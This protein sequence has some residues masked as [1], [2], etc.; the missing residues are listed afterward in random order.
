[1]TFLKFII[2]T[3][4]GIL[5]F[6]GHS[7]TATA[8]VNCNDVKNYIEQTSIE[9]A[10]YLIDSVEDTPQLCSYYV[11]QAF[12]DKGKN[13]EA[14]LHIKKI[15]SLNFRREDFY[16]DAL[17]LKLLLLEGELEDNE[18]SD[19]L[20]EFLN[21]GRMD[22]YN[23]LTEEKQKRFKTQYQQLCQ[24][25]FGKHTQLKI[26][27]PYLAT[28]PEKKEADT[29]LR[30]IADISDKDKKPLNQKNSEAILDAFTGL[31]TTCAAPKVDN[32]PIL[33]KHTNLVSYFELVKIVKDETKVSLKDLQERRDKGKKALAILEKYQYQTNSV[34]TLISQI[35]QKIKVTTLKGLLKH[36]RL[37]TSL[38]KVN[39][40]LTSLSKYWN[41]ETITSQLS[42]TEQKFLNILRLYDE[43]LA[44]EH[45][46]CNTLSN[47]ETGPGIQKSMVA[48]A[49]EKI[50][51]IVTQV[52]ELIQNKNNFTLKAAAKEAL[53]IQNENS[54]VIQ[55][56]S[57]EKQ[58]AIQ[59]KIQIFQDIAKAYDSADRNWIEI[60]QLSK[61]IGIIKNFDELELAKVCADK[62][63]S[64]N[65]K[66]KYLDMVAEDNEDAIKICH[67]TLSSVKC[68]DPN[69]DAK[70]IKM[71]VKF[72]MADTLMPLRL[73]SSD[74]NKFNKAIEQVNKHLTLLLSEQVDTP[75]I[76]LP[77]EILMKKLIGIGKN[78]CRATNSL[79][80]QIEDVKNFF[81][82]L[83]ILRS[84]K[85]APNQN[86]SDIDKLLATYQGVEKLITVD[87]K[88]KETL[89]EA[90][91][92]SN[93]S[94][95][96]IDEQNPT[97]NNGDSS[98]VAKAVGSTSNEI[99]QTE[100]IQAVPKNNDDKVQ[101][102]GSFGSDFN[103]QKSF[104][105]GILSDNNRLS[106]HH[107]QFT[108]VKE[109]RDI[110]GNIQYFYPYFGAGMDVWIGKKNHSDY[111][112]KKIITLA[113]AVETLRE[114]ID[115][116]NALQQANF[117]AFIGV[118]N[119]MMSDED[120]REHDNR[121]QRGVKS[122][123]TQLDKAYF[124]SS[125][126]Q[127]LWYLERQYYEKSYG[128]I[129]QVYWKYK[130][131]DEMNQFS[132]LLMK[133]ISDLG[134]LNQINPQKNCGKY[135]YDY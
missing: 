76:P 124:A 80:K 24:N 79:E 131:T 125:F 117:Q 20:N 84:A 58:N 101:K 89:V 59:S 115:N 6:F 23:K 104:F 39:T 61:S 56:L 120:I 50:N 15:T 126:F 69:L 65:T 64:I 51:N 102:S 93:S 8:A 48:F 123:V 87:A 34:K 29:I 52:N 25:P 121:I 114:G 19:A 16:L 22:L 11:A 57:R 14:R 10:I 133:A 113:K 103:W 73:V 129:C 63:N 38:S 70:L 47:K 5:F 21:V 81:I 85:K 46:S 53:R 32:H 4:I 119:D 43:C 42:S 2:A 26:D 132:R 7:D 67:T 41:N 86:R 77:V 95:A 33:V 3:I 35:E 99:K 17:Y 62:Q 54:Q 12:V 60:I 108:K 44:G 134:H 130:F 91:S 96:K 100:E 98:P 83:K 28:M 105:R 135:D 110:D 92:I 106:N 112:D 55:V 90:V 1:M 66:V 49:I 74:D 13:K 18:I 122:R 128:V 40:H 36:I 111:L 37:Q 109:R 116:P 88:L 72:I 107:R 78:H 30:L 127:G 118:I 45:L 94:V 27:S 31:K 97:G 82:Q 9:D 75:Y 71:V 68:F